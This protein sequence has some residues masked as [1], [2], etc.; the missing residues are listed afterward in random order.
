MSQV[1]YYFPVLAIVKIKEQFP[2]SDSTHIFSPC[3]LIILL[4]LLS[5]RPEP[6]LL[7]GT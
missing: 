2:C 4:A 1:L 3:A 5:P 6:F 7:P